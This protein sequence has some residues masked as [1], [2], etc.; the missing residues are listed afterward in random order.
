MPFKDPASR[1]KYQRERY[2]RQKRTSRPKPLVRGLKSPPAQKFTLSE[3]S[4]IIG[5]TLAQPLLIGYFSFRTPGNLLSNLWMLAIIWPTSTFLLWVLYSR[6]GIDKPKV[7][8]EIIPQESKTL[9]V[10]D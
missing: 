10:P 7:G 5:N 1:R 3:L 9:I 6:V 4:P 8:K 2:A